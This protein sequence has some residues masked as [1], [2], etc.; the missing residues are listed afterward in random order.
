MATH[1]DILHPFAL[2]NTRGL[3]L[4][5]DPDSDS[6]NKPKCRGLFFKRQASSRQITSLFR[7]LFSCSQTICC[8]DRLPAPSQARGVSHNALSPHPPVL[9]PCA[10]PGS[11]AL[12]PSQ[13][14]FIFTARSFLLKEN[15]GRFDNKG[16]IRRYFLRRSSISETD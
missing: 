2:T 15:G 1:R 16:G 11:G 10:P 6:C 13:I 12:N 9:Q 5:A 7:Q 3:Y 4:K 8:C 14:L